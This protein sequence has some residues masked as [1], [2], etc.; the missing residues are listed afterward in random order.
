MTES[1]SIRLPLTATNAN[2]MTHNP[3]NPLA[4]QVYARFK[5]DIFEFRLL[6]G[7]HFTETEMAARYDVSRTPMRDALYRLQRDGFLEVGFRRGWR[8]RKLDFA[9]FDDLYDLRIVLETAAMER[10]CQMPDQP[11][12]LL[13]LKDIWL[14]PKNER[15]KDGRTVA[16]LDESFHTTLVSA[17]ANGEMTRVHTDLTEKIRVIR[18]LDFTQ[19]ARIDA[20]YQEHAKIL[21]FLLRK[22]FAEASLLLRSHIQLSK[23]EVRKITLHRLHEAHAPG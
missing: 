21:Q 6:P 15:E 1:S 20:T 14:V 4:E 5:E 7:D 10:I 19:T 11:E 9:Y 16:C 2:A 12:K 18:R 23:L 17:A 8:V 22:K 3:A 13:K